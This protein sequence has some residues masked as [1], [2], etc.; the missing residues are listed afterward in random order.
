MKN[1]LIPTHL[2]PDTEIAVRTAICSASGT[3]TEIML[4][5][6]AD[7]PTS[8]SASALLRSMRHELTASQLSVLD[9]CRDVARKSGFSLKFHTQYSLSGP[10]LRNLLQAMETGLVIIPASYANST[11]STHTSCVKWLSLSKLPILQ[12]SETATPELRKALLI[13]NGLGQL[14]V[15]ELQLQINRKL[16]I[17]IVSQANISS[18]EQS[19]RQLLSETIDLRDIDVLIH[20]RRTEKTGRRKNDAAFPESF[21]LSVLSVYEN[22]I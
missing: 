18:E 3:G 14:P 5:L 15:H 12:L 1:I 19:L 16:P 17:Q 7:A 10:L 20:T 9:D 4:L 22:A 6:T 13:E 8:E 21:G 2:S 11:Q